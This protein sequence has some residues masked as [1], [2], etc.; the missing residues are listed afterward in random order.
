MNF[1]LDRRTLLGLF[2][3][4]ARAAG[5]ARP[6]PPSRPFPANTHYPMLRTRIAGEVTQLIN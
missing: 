3:G 4:L 2:H 1:D 5:A 6:L